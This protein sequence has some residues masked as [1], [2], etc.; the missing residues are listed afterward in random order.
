MKY[1]RKKCFTQR[2]AA[3]KK[4]INGLERVHQNKL[5]DDAFLGSEDGIPYCAQSLNVFTERRIY[6][7]H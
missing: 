3:V 1:L 6:T 2:N 5:L 4:T 7:F